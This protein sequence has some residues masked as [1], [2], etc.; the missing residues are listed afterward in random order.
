MYTRTGRPRGRPP[1]ADVASSKR[2]SIQ[3]TPDQRAALHQTA[4]ELHLSVTGLIRTAV[5]VLVA[6]S[7]E[8]PI[9][10]RIR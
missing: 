4:R 10:R 7:G 2:L 8:P 6:D 3:F 5:N 1:V 9:F